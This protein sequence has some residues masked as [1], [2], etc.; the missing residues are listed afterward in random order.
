M[1]GTF[2]NSPWVKTWLSRCITCET[3]LSNTGDLL[4]YILLLSDIRLFG[5]CWY[6]ALSRSFL[7]VTCDSDIF[8]AFLRV[9][10]ASLETWLSR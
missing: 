5:I 6:C 4:R 8:C 7:V 9:R 2:W 1:C 3:T 10:L